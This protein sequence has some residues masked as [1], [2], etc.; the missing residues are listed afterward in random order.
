MRIFRFSCFF[1][2]DD[3]RVSFAYFGGDG[4]QQEEVTHH[5]HDA[6]GARGV[7][8]CGRR[9]GGP[10]VVAPGRGDGLG[11]EVLGEGVPELGAGRVALA[12]R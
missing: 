3:G 4:L 8:A 7:G 6:V 12:Y 10:A 2:G 11:V 5:E 1:W 9:G